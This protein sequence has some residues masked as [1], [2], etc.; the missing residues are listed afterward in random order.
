[1]AKFDYM[2]FTGCSPTEFVVH[3]NKY[4]KE[5]AIELAVKE[6]SLGSTPATDSVYE[7]WCRYYIRTPDWCGYDGDSNSGCYTY[8]G[9]G[10]RGAFPVW[11]I[12]AV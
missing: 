11:V 9:K 8:C 6:L 4:N 5:Q 12:E 10:E 2:L 3:A 7:R 1:M